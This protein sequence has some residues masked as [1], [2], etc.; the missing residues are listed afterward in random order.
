[1]MRLPEWYSFFS[2]IP[3]TF[4]CKLVIYP[5]K[6]SGLDKIY[7][8]YWQREVEKRIQFYNIVQNEENFMFYCNFN[9]G[10]L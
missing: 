9:L 6:L 4:N 10:Y 5:V 7:A 2:F 3:S 1:M 8:K